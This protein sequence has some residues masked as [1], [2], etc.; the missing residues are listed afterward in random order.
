MVTDV[1][2]AC[3]YVKIV[4]SNDFMEILEDYTKDIKDDEERESSIA[5]INFNSQMLSDMIPN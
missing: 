1:F 5:T 4:S 3:S 2:N